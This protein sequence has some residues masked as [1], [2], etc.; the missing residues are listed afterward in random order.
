MDEFLQLDHM[1]LVKTDEDDTNT[2]YLPHHAVF[3][4]D[5]SKKIR[6]VFNASQKYGNGV[7]LNDYLLMGPKLQADISLIITRW[8]FNKFVFVTDIFKMFRQVLLH[9]DDTDWQR[10]VWRRDCT[11]PI[12][13]FRLKTVTYGTKPAPFLAIRLLHQ[14]HL[15]ADNE[16]KFP[17]AASV[18]VTKLC[19]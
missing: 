1:E 5:G 9:S 18:Y 16:M 2:N 4:D 7:S 19:G 8:R 15:A 10:I 6:V 3:R 13:D 17:A 11:Q 12:Q 14:Q